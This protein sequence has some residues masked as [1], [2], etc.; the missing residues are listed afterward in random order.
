M[1]SVRREAGWRRAEAELARAAR[2]GEPILAGPFLGEVGYELLYWIPLLR[3][4]LREHEIP[5]ER[6][7]VLARGG[8]GAWYRDLAA[9]EVEVIELVG[10]DRFHDELLAR[11]R[12]ASDAKQLTV[13]PFDLELADAAR[14][15]AGGG[16]LLHPRLMYSRLRFV[17]EGLVA[18]ERMPELVDQRPLE[19]T[20]WGLAEGMP[21]PDRFVAVKAYFSHVLPESEHTRAF[22]ERLVAS[23]AEDVDV[24]VLANPTVLDEHVEW[25]AAGGR[26]HTAA[27]WLE[28]RTN[29]A[30]QTEIVAAA[31]G[32]VCTYGGFSYL[33]PL[34]GTPTTALYAVEAE[35]LVH[36]AVARATL[37]PVPFERVE[38]RGLESVGDVVASMTGSQSR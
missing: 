35:N 16:H 21:L 18:P 6:V 9:N 2:R 4:L 26:V 20:G 13:D 32:L 10:V 37:P 12:R 33:G 30:V 1:D 25:S 28:P 38:V 19:V 14:H 15:R 5:S 24:V 11:R 36:L 17:W 27:A 23:L 31:E 29:L 34:V 8:A 22:L 3:R 7:T